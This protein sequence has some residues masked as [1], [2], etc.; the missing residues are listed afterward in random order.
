MNRIDEKKGH[1]IG[2]ASASSSGIG[3][4]EETVGLEPSSGLLLNGRI[5]FFFNH[6]RTT[7]IWQQKNK[8]SLDID[9]RE[10]RRR[11]KNN[12]EKK[13]WV[14]SFHFFFSLNIPGGISM[15]SAG[16]EPL[17][18]WSSVAM[19][20]KEPHAPKRTAI[21]LT[22]SFDQI[23]R[24]SKCCASSSNQQAAGQR[25]QTCPYSPTVHQFS[26]TEKEKTSPTTKRKWQVQAR[27]M[28]K[29]VRQ[30]SC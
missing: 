3:A 14:V 4:E 7:E 24:W 10:K 18:E 27:Q 15:V 11:S 8:R 12:Q 13:K 28:V 21:G 20:S 2:K 5:L 30:R 23:A 25:R 6:F 1:A 22:D 9:Q 16:S 17:M 19:N 26:P 29:S